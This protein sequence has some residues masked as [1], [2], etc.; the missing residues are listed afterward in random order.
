MFYIAT[1]FLG[2]LEIYNNNAAEILCIC[3]ENNRTP[4]S[5]NDTYQTIP[6]K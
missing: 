4:D 3:I 2:Q 5:R 6:A 1:G